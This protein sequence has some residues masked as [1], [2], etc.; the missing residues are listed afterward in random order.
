ML[1]QIFHI[2]K[3]PGHAWRLGGGPPG[4]P[5]DQLAPWPGESRQSLTRAPANF[6]G[7]IRPPYTPHYVKQLCKSNPTLMSC[8][9][10]KSSWWAIYLG[11]VATT[12]AQPVVITITLYSSV[13]QL[14]SYFSPIRYTYSAKGVMAMALNLQVDVLTLPHPNK[15]YPPI[16]LAIRYVVVAMEPYRRAVYLKQ[17]LKRGRVP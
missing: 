12:V 1:G 5:K 8:L 15:L 4:W 2:V 17:I 14:Y 9:A 13:S 10:S 3:K 11:T 6:R 16:H 7:L